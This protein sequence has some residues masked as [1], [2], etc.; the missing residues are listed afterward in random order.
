[1][2]P[3]DL[4][5]TAR[6]SWALQPPAW[7]GRQSIRAWPQLPQRPSCPTLTLRGVPPR[8]WGPTG[9]QD[10]SNFTLTLGFLSWGHK[11]E[12]SGRDGCP[13]PLYSFHKMTQHTGK[14]LPGHAGGMAGS[15][16]HREET[17]GHSW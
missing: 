15:L 11:K 3:G 7:T 2:S 16:G 13:H 5:T 9:C 6:R 8:P 1:M 17:R 10:L 12:G 14:P 4:G